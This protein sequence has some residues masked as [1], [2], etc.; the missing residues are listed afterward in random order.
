MGFA[1]LGVLTSVVRATVGIQWDE[2]SEMADIV[3]VIDSD[4][5]Q[6]IQVYLLLETRMD[7]ILR[8]FRF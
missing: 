2:N 7:T 1:S 3:S 8:V 6:A 5:G 4:I